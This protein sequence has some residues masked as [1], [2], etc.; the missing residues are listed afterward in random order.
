MRLIFGRGGF[1]LFSAYMLQL[2]AGRYDDGLA[3]R[4]LGR[5]EGLDRP[6]HLH[7]VGHLA[8][9]GVLAVEPLCLYRRDEELRALRVGA[10]VGHREQPRLGVLDG[11]VLVGEPATVDTLA[12]W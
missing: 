2:A 8:E 3:R 9:D 7:A 10:G 11:E 6:G 12:A 5:A 4:A 1:T